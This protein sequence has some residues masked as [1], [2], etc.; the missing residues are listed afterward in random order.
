[1]ESSGDSVPATRSPAAL[2]NVALERA[3]PAFFLQFSE[4]EPKSDDEVFPKTHDA[5]GSAS[6]V[7]KR[8]EKT[9]SSSS[10]GEEEE[11]AVNVVE[12]DA[13]AKGKQVATEGNS[14]DSDS[15]D[16]SAYLI[17]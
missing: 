4:P 15:S 5:T 16:S 9:A 7:E 13:A 12:S 17:S 2:A 3:M 14:D 10:G 8:A 6:E 11:E 1:M